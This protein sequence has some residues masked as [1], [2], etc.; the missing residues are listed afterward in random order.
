ME[1]AKKD[2]NLKFAVN[3]PFLPIPLTFVLKQQVRL[4]LKGDVVS[5]KFLRPLL[6]VCLS[7]CH[8]AH[9]ARQREGYRGL[10]SF[11]DEQDRLHDCVNRCLKEIHPVEVLLPKKWR[12]KFAFLSLQVGRLGKAYL[13]HASI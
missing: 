7:V 4:S 9:N 10:I 13:D 5:W 3:V 11:R 6:S 1:F 12:K 2:R 8:V